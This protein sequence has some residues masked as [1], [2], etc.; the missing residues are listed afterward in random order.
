MVLRGTDLLLIKR[1]TYTMST[2]NEALSLKCH[3]LTLCK[4]HDGFLKKRKIHDT[5]IT[6]G[7]LTIRIAAYRLTNSFNV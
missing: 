5:K 4:T 6:L 7:I 2:S 1:L 3:Q